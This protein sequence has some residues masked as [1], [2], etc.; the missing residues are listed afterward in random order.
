MASRWQRSRYIEQLDPVHDH[1]EICQLLAGYEFPWDIT[2]AL[3]IALFRTFCVPSVSQLLDRTGEFHHRPQKR[4]DDTGLIVSE[5][6]K[7]G[8]DSEPGAAAIDRM[9]R[10]HGHF[11]ISNEDFLYVLST[12][13]YEPIRWIERFGWR[14]LSTSE[15]QALFYFWK[16]VG[17]RM[18]IGNIPDDYG[19][20]EQFNQAYEQ[21]HFYYS[22]SN[23]RVGDATLSMLVG[24]FP[25]WLRPVVRPSVYAMLDDA[26]LKAFGFAT[27]PDQVRRAIA[28]TLKIRGWVMGSLPPRTA[29]D[30]FVDSKLRSYPD[31][32]TLADVGPPSMRSHLNAP[33]AHAPELDAEAED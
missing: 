29:P 30:F 16:A 28:Q 2:R 24:W 10:I 20:F 32:F 31:G 5:I 1:V 21:Q 23:R 14:S 33:P 26:M 7:C 9:N 3:E 8:Y 22:D 13:I 25:Q 18:G 27:P 15:K 17:D 12:F 19:T 6:L 4:Y 11:P